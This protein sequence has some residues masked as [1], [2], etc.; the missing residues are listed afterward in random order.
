MQGATAQVSARAPDAAAPGSPPLREPVHDARHP[1][2]PALVAEAVAAVVLLV[3]ASALPAGA[4][5]PLAV[6]VGVALLTARAALGAARAG[7]PGLVAW[8]GLAVLQVAVLAPGLDRPGDTRVVMTLVGLGAIVFVVALVPSVAAPGLF[9][10]RRE[11][12]TPGLVAVAVAGGI[13]VLAAIGLSGA[14]GADDPRLAALVPYVAAGMAVLALAEVLAHHRAGAGHPETAAAIVVVAVV[15]QVL[16]LVD[17]RDAPLDTAVTALVVAGAMAATGLLVA[18]ALSTPRRLVVPEAEAGDG[19]RLIGW[20]FAGLLAAAVAA[21]LAV[22]RPLWIDEAA[23]AEVTGGSLGRLLDATRT[24]DAHP[25]LVDGLAWVSRQIL[26]AGD[27]ALRAPSL[28]AGIALVPAVY[29]AATRLFDR[30]AGIVAAV[31]AA[32]GP[33]L[34]WLS[35]SAGPGMV[36]ALLATLALV[37]MLQAVDRGRPLDWIVF[38]V[39]GAVLVWSHQLA[40]LHAAVLVGAAGVVVIERRRRAAGTGGAVAGWATA[41]VLVG[42][43]FAVLV[44]YRHGLGPPSVPPPLEYATSGAPGAGRSVLGLAGTAVTGILGF[45]PRDVTSRLLALW[46]LAILATFALAVRAWTRRGLLLAAL[47][48]T[49]FVALLVLQV[50][51]MPRSPLFALE[52]TATAV[53]MI[54]IG[55]A[56]AATVAGAWPRARLLAAIG[57]AVLVLAAADQA[58][59]VEPVDRVDVTPAVDEVAAE[60]RAGDLVIYAPAA[61]GDLVR[62]E[63]GD[64]DVVGLRRGGERAADTEGRVFVVGA[65]SFADDDVRD[66]VLALVTDISAD[67]P[68]A[69]ENRYG[70]TTVWSFG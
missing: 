34:V 44:S 25:P 23:T 2:V 60:A 65:F 20:A 4:R 70:D 17:T 39:T 19:P 15:A 24:A 7:A 42:A 53:P 41:A 5:A 6:A 45:H 68:L 36:T 26:G 30:R 59:R 3:G 62:H 56:R 28:L 49:P 14:V 32:L 16:M 27:L 9:E 33:G 64:A 29:I 22:S 61:V 55:L 43:S 54:A 37:T 47:A 31:I 58:I 13:G 40:V 8:G 66:E 67:R 50:A 51:G 35:G 38:G 10:G 52:W 21:R 46:P 48:A 12:V 1:M 57:A 18:T 63:V 69:S 11:D